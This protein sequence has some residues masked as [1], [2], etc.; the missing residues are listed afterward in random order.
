[1]VE[2]KQYVPF[3]ITGP[4]DAEDARKRSLSIPLCFS[5]KN[6]WVPLPCLQVGLPKDDRRRLRYWVLGRGDR[7]PG[8]QGAQE[9]EPSLPGL[10]GLLSG[11]Q[12]EGAVFRKLAAH[13]GGTF[14]L[15]RVVRSKRE[16]APITWR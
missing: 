1:M 8:V 10:P 7:M 3:C 6:D 11:T 14:S 16:E 5:K 13:P 15:T 4:F 12:L 9:K 2:S